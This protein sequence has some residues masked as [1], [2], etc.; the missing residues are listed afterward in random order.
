MATETPNDD[1]VYTPLAAATKV[2]SSACASISSS[3]TGSASRDIT[4]LIHITNECVELV[5]EKVVLAASV[6]TN[7]ATEDNNSNSNVNNNNNDNGNANKSWDC[8]F[9]VPE[10]CPIHRTSKRG[11]D[12]E[13]D[14]IKDDNENDNDD[15]DDDDD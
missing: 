8:L 7:D 3:T 5:G 13:H 9:G 14:E 15:D 10:F 11:S 2:D 12:S 1:A 4:N 6:A